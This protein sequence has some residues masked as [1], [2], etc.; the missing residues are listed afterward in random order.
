MV[1]RSRSGRGAAG[2]G[3]TLVELLFALALCGAIVAVAVPATE[4]AVDELRTAM[5]AR[6]IAGRLGHARIEA[7]K[8]A[9]CIGLRFE[10][11]ADDYSVTGYMDGNANGIRSLDIAAGIDPRIAGPEQLRDKFPGVH[12]GLME[13][14]ADADGAKGTGTDGVRI[15]KAH[16]CTMSPDGT[17]TAGTLYIRGRRSQY[18]VRVL[19]ATGR[20]RLLQY[21]P[22]DGQWIAH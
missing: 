20:V 15:G 22:K 4:D 21:R 9:T 3:F 17:A 2:D 13:N 16:I 6:Y 14:A 12:F 5:A 18:A 1:Q 11:K 10:A 8:R 19:G 7:V